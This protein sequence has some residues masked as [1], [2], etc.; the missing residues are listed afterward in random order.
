MTRMRLISDAYRE[1]KQEDPET[2]LT[3]NALKCMVRQ[4]KIPCKKSGRKT[5]I[6]YDA[7]LEYL[8]S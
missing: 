6:N 8:A 1:I 2:A 5:F 7:L 4:G 3:L